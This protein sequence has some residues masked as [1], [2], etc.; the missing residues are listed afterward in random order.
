MGIKDRLLINFYG[1]V[2]GIH[3][4]S[5]PKSLSTEEEKALTG[6]K[7]L[8]YD[9]GGDPEVPHLMHGGSLIH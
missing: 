6:L 2:T 1:W 8:L 7:P 5:S 4:L 3:L 9:M